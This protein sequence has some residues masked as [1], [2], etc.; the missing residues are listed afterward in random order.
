[1]LLLKFLMLRYR[2]PGVARVP[3]VKE[4]EASADVGIPDFKALE[5]RADVGVS[6]V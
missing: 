2:R 3:D 6:D 4:I 5:A 1:M